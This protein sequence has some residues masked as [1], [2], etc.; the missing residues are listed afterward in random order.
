MKIKEIGK[1]SRGETL[2]IGD[3]VDVEQCWEDEAGCYHDESLTIS[4]IRKDGTLRF[5]IGHWKNRTQKEQQIQ[6]F[7]NSCEFYPEDVVKTI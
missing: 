6:A 2:F 5:R 3:N 4:G 7:I 1:D